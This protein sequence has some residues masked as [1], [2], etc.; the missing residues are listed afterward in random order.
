MDE[1]ETIIPEPPVTPF[2]RAEAAKYALVQGG[3]IL[4]QQAPY[5]AVVVDTSQYEKGRALFRLEW[6]GGEVLN[7]LVTPDELVP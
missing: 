7:V 4:S 2:Q 1:S 6:P 5:R 3:G